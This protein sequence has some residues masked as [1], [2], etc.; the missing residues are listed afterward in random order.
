MGVGQHGDKTLVDLARRRAGESPA[1]S[2]YTFLLDG[3]TEACELTYGEL[4]RRARAIAAWLQSFGARDERAI[5]LFPPGLDYI[6]AF[7][8]CLYAQVVAVPAYPPLRKRTMG[9]LQAVLADSGAIFALTTGKIRANIERFADQEPETLAGLSRLRWLETDAVPAAIEDQWRRPTVTGETLAFLQYT[10]GSTGSPKG[11]MVG[12]DNLLHNQHMIR[13]AFG[14]TAQTTV[15]GWLPLYHDMGLIGNVLQPLYLGRPCVLMS[16]AHFMQRPFRW[17]SAISRYRATT[18]GAPNFAYDLCVRHVNEE[19]R[20]S[21]DLSSWSVAFNGAEPIHPGTLDRFTETF[22]PCGFRR[23]AFYP[24]YGLAEA[25]LFVSGGVHGR[26]PMLRNVE[27]AALA[28]ARLVDSADERDAQRLVGCGISGLDQQIRIVDPDSRTVR[29]DGAVGEVWV[30]GPS[31]ARGYWNRRDATAQ[32]FEAVIA[33]SGEG[34]FL[35]TGDLGVTKD[36][37]LFVV[38]RLKDLII[39][40]GRNHYP[41]D[42]EATVQGVHPALRAGGSAAFSVEVESDEQLVVVQELAGRA[43]LDVEAL[44]ADIRQAVAEHHEIQVHAVVLIKQGTLPKTSSGKVQRRLCREKFLTDGLDTIRAVLQTGG[45][46]AVEAHAWGP[47]DSVERAIA[48]VWAQVLGRASVGPDD[49]FFALGGDSLRGTQVLVRLRKIY[50]V[51]VSLE[52]LFDTPTVAGLAALVESRRLAELPAIKQPSGAARERRMDVMPLSYSQDRFW[53]LDQLS[54]DSPFNNIP[55]ALHIAG[56]LDVPA[57]ERAHAEIIR[58]HDILRSLFVLDGGRPGQRIV[59]PVDGV[60]SI[61]DLSAFAGADRE[62]RLRRAMT[63]EAR[64]LFDLSR[65]PVLRTRLLRLGESEHVLLLTVHHI[66]ADG[67]SMRVLSREL[68][69]LYE[70]FLAGLPSPLPALPVQYVDTVLRQREQADGEEW[71][72]QEHYW[73][74]QLEGAPHTLTLPFDFP[75]PA[76][77]GQSGA[78]HAWTIDREIGTRIDALSRTRRCSS[79]MTLL[80]AFDVLLSRYSGQTDFC[81]GTPVANRGKLDSEDLIGCFVNT[82]AVRADLSGDPPFI[83]LLE[84]V[85][86]TVLGAQAHQDVPFERLV[87]TLQIPRSL[88]HT[89]IYQVMMVLEDNPPDLCR[90]SGCDVRRMATSTGTSAF[91]LALELTAQPDGSVSAVLEYSTDLF[92]GDTMARMATHFDELLR[93]IVRRPQARLSELAMLSGD[94]RAA[95]LVDCNRTAADYPSSH[96]LHHLFEEQARMRPDAVALVAEGRAYGYADVDARSNRLAAY[97][98]SR[99]LTTETRVALCVERSLEMVVG[100]LGVLKAGAAYVPMDPAYPGDRLAFM[101]RDSG[102]E[103]LLIQGRSRPAVSDC[104]V[105]VLALDEE[106]QSVAAAPSLAAPV[107]VGPDN[108][109]YV[110]YTS[111]TTGRPKGTAISHRSLVNHST[112]MVR[113]YGLGPGD[114]VLQFASVS[115]DVAAEECFPSWAAGATVV[116]RPN[117]PVTAFADLHRFILDH[118]LTLLNLPTPYW[119]DWTEVMEQNGT[120]LPPSVRLVVVGSEKALPDNLARWQRL[121]GDRIAWCNSYGPTEATVTASYFVPGED[122]SWMSLAA[123]PIGRPISNVQLYVL[124]SSLQPVP[125]GIAGELCIGGVGLARGYHGQPGLT[126]DRFVPHGFSDQPGARL[127]RT[128]D[129]VRRRPDGNLDFL[130][131]GDDQIKI[132]GFRVEPAEIEFWSREHADVKDVRVY[133]ESADRAGEISAPVRLVGYAVLREGSSLSMQ[134]LRSFLAER[135]PEYMVPAVWVFLDAFPLTERGKVDREA[136]RALVQRSPETPAAS[137]PPETETEQ[138]I[139]EIWKDAL[140]VAAV[141]RQDN[142]FDLGGHS[143]LLAKILTSLR[144][145]SRRPLAMLDLFRYPTVQSL[146]AYLEGSGDGTDRGG[147][148]ENADLAHRAKERRTAGVR[149][150]RRQREQ[151]QGAKDGI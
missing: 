88:S 150:L 25:T 29:P 36:G 19:E 94:E 85:R 91:D 11:V 16:P 151:R 1:Q 42:I 117:E 108:L 100:L 77:Q 110:L 132:R 31:V 20:A 50:D 115:F 33:E 125:A 21:L 71:K 107:S 82:V 136:L 112:A 67:W 135:L 74:R 48:G 118:G 34:P 64:R 53:F 131:R 8:G 103:L 84:R 137:S 114:R 54:P 43:G 38:G 75:R 86:K 49:D 14:H 80:A 22:G 5:L 104:G 2:A 119:A 7:I 24:C 149:R 83:E 66:A 96:C 140:G 10:S 93:Q 78:R 32:T 102:A 47:A 124:D 4:D 41:H 57:L 60:L 129:R 134:Q 98:R 147:A 95:V 123:V 76:V 141:G 13:Q 45:A 70:A 126:A 35:R 59:P 51:D 79:F 87:E 30:K 139:A 106:W 26:A 6:A 27:K 138:A 37:E 63:D 72:K 23:E 18:S 105:P 9:R 69:R 90:L 127:Y 58:R 46:P 120:T 52:S 40:R 142:F 121:V 145:L 143:L 144:S 92:A 109:A 133:L 122:R 56:P 15:L 130:G 81:V 113:H 97:L 65:G 44:I 128:G 3:E 99:G 61:D 62:E 146:A 89:P 101:I 39:I 68:S 148:E 116:L 28:Q 55:V 12:H 73:R 111:G 17:L